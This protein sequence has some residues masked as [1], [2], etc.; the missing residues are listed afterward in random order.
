MKH[1]GRPRRLFFDVVRY[2]VLVGV[3]GEQI[4]EC[5]K[6]VDCAGLSK[7]LAEMRM[8]L[9][10]LAKRMK[11]LSIKVDWWKEYKVQ[12]KGPTNSTHNLLIKIGW[13]RD[14]KML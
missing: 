12:V 10:F 1:L 8:G 7:D 6:T 14:F 3:G 9:W 11:C 13:R 5:L 2:A 4:P